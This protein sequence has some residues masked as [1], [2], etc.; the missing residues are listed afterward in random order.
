M[1]DN[2][3]LGRGKVFF[4]PYPKNQVT[5]GIKGYFG[6]T[7]TMTLAQTNTQL[8]HYSSEGGLKIKDKSILLQTDMKITFDCDNINYGNLA[9]WFGGNN[10]E[11]LPA[12]A[13]SDIGTMQV[14]GSADAVYGAL[15]F[16]SD[17]PVGDNN[18]FWWPYV[19]LMPNGNFA[20]KGDAWQTMSFTAEA[21]KR[22]N[23][24][25]RVYVYA[26][27]DGTSTAAADT[28]TPEFSVEAAMVSDT[29]IASTATLTADTPQVHL[30]PFDVTWTLD[31]GT[32]GDRVAY[33]F[34]N[35]GTVVTSTMT[36]VA[37]ETGTASMTIPAT[38]TVHIQ[39]FNNIAGTG[40]AI[41]VSGSIVTT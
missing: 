18:N 20:L 15:F 35:N 2:L 13:P 23:A 24:T 38:G 27:T 11:A 7:P 9:L 22:D 5:G 1:A 8:D 21:L 30:V 29:F 39:A 10:E 28:T 40:S 6:N 31:G 34:V 16:E 25:E 14:V 3:V 17:N 4:A 36:E 26:P 32:A 41:G 19:L 37:G 12:D 33:L